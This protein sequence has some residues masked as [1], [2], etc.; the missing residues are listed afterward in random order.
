LGHCPKHLAK[1]GFFFLFLLIFS[2]GFLVL[3][4]CSYAQNGG[5]NPEEIIKE[6]QIQLKE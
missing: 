3:P 1:K 2:A 4:G 6:Q 5:L